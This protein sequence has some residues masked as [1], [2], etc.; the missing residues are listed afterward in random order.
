M[1]LSKPLLL[2]SVC[3]LL[4][5]CQSA[6]QIPVPPSPSISP[7][8]TPIPTPSSTPS[9]TATPQPNPTVIVTGTP[10]PTATP[11]NRY[12]LPLTVYAANTCRD[13]AGIRLYSLYHTGGF[14][15]NL[16]SDYRDPSVLNA[17]STSV[18][19]D[20]IAA[21]EVILKAADLPNQARLNQLGPEPGACGLNE[22]YELTIDGQTQRFELRDG[23]GGYAPGYL[24]GIRQLREHL[25]A[26][27]VK[28]PDAKHPCC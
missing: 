7:S 19:A 27:K 9:P 20:D 22:T 18:T 13:P 21:T 5:A 25:D 28:Y 11:N 4:A 1:S 23:R 6:S 17:G 14:V 16:S 8:P 2:A 3:L 15:Y 26:L 12:G 10:L 24:S